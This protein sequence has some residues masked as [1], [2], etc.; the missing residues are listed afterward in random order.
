M[1][2]I[3]KISE[4]FELIYKQYYNNLPKIEKKIEDGLIE[5]LGLR[6]ENSEIN[7]DNQFDGV[8]SIMQFFYRSQSSNYGH[9]I[10]KSAKALILNQGFEVFDN[11]EGYLT[12]DIINKINNIKTYPNLLKLEYRSLKN[13]AKD[14]VNDF[15]CLLKKEKQKIEE[16][17]IGFKLLNKK[18]FT[19]DFNTSIVLYNRL[20]SDNN[21]K[22][23]QDFLIKHEDIVNT[24]IVNNLQEIDFIR[25]NYNKEMDSLK[26]SVN[27]SLSDHEVKILINKDIL[28]ENKKG[29]IKIN[30]KLTEKDIDELVKNKVIKNKEYILSNEWKYV[31]Q[32]GDLIYIQAGV[33]K[34]YEIKAG[35][36]L[37]SKSSPSNKENLLKLFCIAFNNKENLKINDVN[38]IYGIS[39]NKNLTDLSNIKNCFIEEEFFTGMYF[40]KQILPDC[41]YDIIQEL[42][43]IYNGYDLTSKDLQKIIEEKLI[44]VLS[45]ISCEKDY[46]KII[47]KINID[48]LENKLLINKIRK[49]VLIQLNKSYDRNIEICYKKMK[50]YKVEKLG[51]TKIDLNKFSS[52]K[53]ISQQFSNF[54]INNYIK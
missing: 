10:E 15:Y 9:F 35:G 34:I 17:L 22:E 5:K 14:F 36:N 48:G 16:L 7:I 49:D 40:W 21:F 8:N 43:D 3:N 12:K 4:I 50:K 23:I 47:V 11:L 33:M 27:E 41:D 37:D 46:L 6:C 25:I 32:E 44:N 54:L 42:L 1:L 24:F 52:K 39:E 26:N 13:E 53:I 45:K 31:K 19:I 18:D 28:N 51:Y 29:V 30:R 20:K 2:K 38:I